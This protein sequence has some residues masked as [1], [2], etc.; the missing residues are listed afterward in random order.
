MSERLL[1]DILFLYKRTS[2]FII[3]KLNIFLW[4]ER[5]VF[6][7]RVGCQILVNHSF[8]QDKVIWVRRLFELK[9]LLML[10]LF[11]KRNN[12]LGVGILSSWRLV[13]IL[14]FV[15][16]NKYR[17]CLAFLVRI[18]ESWLIFFWVREQI[19]KRYLITSKR[20]ILNNLNIYM[21]RSFLNL[22]K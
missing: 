20:M 14:L 15:F 8:I 19:W 11:V 6:F 17:I 5:M 7:I 22:I 1:I 3:V 13:K 16:V 21:R 12:L 10:I 9:H 4:F 18:L 2:W